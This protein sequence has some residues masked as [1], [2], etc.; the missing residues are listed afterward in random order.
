MALSHE[1]PKEDHDKTSTQPGV[2]TD[3][4]SN[5]SGM[6]VTAA[7]TRSVSQPSRALFRT[8]CVLAATGSAVTHSLSE[9]H[10]TVGTHLT[11]K[12]APRPDLPYLT[13]TLTS[14]AIW[15]AGGGE[16]HE[17]ILVTIAT[18]YIYEELNCKINDTGFLKSKAGRTG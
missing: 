13:H 14:E 1:L 7:I 18:V 6:S 3:T 10:D 12:W 9:Y 5:T 17:P 4:V 2:P 8:H 11:T 16:T 15:S